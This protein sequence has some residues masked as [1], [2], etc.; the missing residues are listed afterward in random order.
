MSELEK[1]IDDLKKAVMNELE[2]KIKP[3][4]ERL[5]SVLNPI[6]CKHKFEQSY[7]SEDFPDIRYWKCKK[8][9]WEGIPSREYR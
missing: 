1:T 9:E 5:A 3:I 7:Q 4:V 6:F 8:C 2:P